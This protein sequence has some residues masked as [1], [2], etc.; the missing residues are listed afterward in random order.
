MDWVLIVTH[1]EIGQPSATAETIRE[2]VSQFRRDE[3]IGFVLRLLGALNADK[4]SGFQTVNRLFVAWGGL[5]AA[6][7][8]SQARQQN[9]DATWLLVEPWQQLLMLQS[10][11][12]YSTEEG[13]VTLKAD[14]GKAAF[15]EACLGINDLTIPKG[16]PTTGDPVSDGLKAAAVISPRLWLDN[17]PNL[18]NAVARMISFLD[19]LP[20]QCEDI[21]PYAD[22]LRLRF[23]ESLGVPFAEALTLTAF[24]GYWAIAGRPEQILDDPASVLIDPEA[25]LE[26]TDIRREDWDRFRA[27]VSAPLDQIAAP[28]A[29]AGGRWFD[30]IRFRD[31][32]LVELPNGLL[33]VSMPELLAEKSSFDIFW[34]LTEGPGGARQR[35][36]WQAAFGKLCERYVLWILQALA[37]ST[38]GV[39]IPNY[40]WNGG[41][42]DALYWDNG[43]LSLFE[44]S[45]SFVNN[46]QRMFWQLG[47][48]SRR[49]CN[50]VC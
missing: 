28:V 16:E 33:F 29:G 25:W 30:P 20:A 6:D 23:E 15:L 36:P 18:N 5:P 41:E 32:P 43:R 8:M 7:V 21:R 26:Q 34:W 11:I 37:D 48:L 19:D 1:A 27:R 44:V 47:R 35:N 40:T 24:L 42:T 38:G 45:G 10:V 2:S 4:G 31:R 13:A 3:A 14:E 50:S 49:S 17:P 46:R 22:L 9:A 12:Q 39:L